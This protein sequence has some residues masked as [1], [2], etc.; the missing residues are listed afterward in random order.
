V[1]R[2]ADAW[3]PTSNLEVQK[4][5]SKMTKAA[6]LL[7]ATVLAAGT[8]LMFA[9]PA[10]ARVVIKAKTGNSW[11]GHI[12]A[13]IGEKVIWR[14]P[15]FSAHNVKSYNQG[16]RWRLQQTQLE[17]NN[18]N[19]VARRFKKR[20]NYYFRCTIHSS[21]DGKGGYNGMVGIVRVRR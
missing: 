13:N 18:G 8:V 16:K 3:W 4:E 14:N 19:Q 15:T 1:G 21:P 6:R 20:G 11:T 7:L 5:M 2:Y 10:A 12:S 17:T 9:A